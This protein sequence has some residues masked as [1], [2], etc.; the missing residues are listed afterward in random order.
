MSGGF[1]PAGFEHLG[2][3]TGYS[4]SATTYLSFVPIAAGAGSRLVYRPIYPQIVIATT[5]V[6]PSGIPAKRPL[7]RV[8]RADFSSQKNYEAALKAALAGA[9]VFIAPTVEEPPEKI[10]T[11]KFK[12][13]D[14][15]ITAS[16][17]D[18][19][20]LQQA[21]EMDEIELLNLFVRVIE[22]DLW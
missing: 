12:A 20:A 18:L 10:K 13:S 2:F 15:A 22:D 16:P 3:E 4:P 14:T 6:T 19:L 8:R 9:N 5:G 17:A 1:A 7:F 21:A 11:R